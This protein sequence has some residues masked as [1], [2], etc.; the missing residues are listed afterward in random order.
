MLNR[1]GCHNSGEPISVVPELKRCVKNSKTSCDNKKQQRRRTDP[2]R[3]LLH[4]GEIVFQD[5][6][7][8]GRNYVLRHPRIIG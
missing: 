2:L 5:S 3:E 4:D 7:S 6:V 8:L 1:Q